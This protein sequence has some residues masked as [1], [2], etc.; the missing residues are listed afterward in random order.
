MPEN[1][2]FNR[3][4]DFDD[5]ARQ[6]KQVSARVELR[7]QP[8][9]QKVHPGDTEEMRREVSSFLL[10]ADFWLE[11][12]GRTYQVPKVYCMSHSGSSSGV[13]RAD[14]DIANS[15]LR[16]DYVRLKE[17]GVELDEQYF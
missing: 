17:A 8:V 10:I 7:E 16:M 9:V 13:S 15:R 6:G 4:V 12:D 2:H 11:V 3:L 1:L 14:R 5:L